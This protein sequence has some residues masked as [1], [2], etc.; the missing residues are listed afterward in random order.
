[1]PTTPSADARRVSRELQASPLRE[2]L[3]DLY[4]RAAARKIRDRDGR[5]WP[6]LTDYEAA[7]MLGVERTS[8]NAARNALVKDGL[9]REHRKR[10]CRH[11]PSRQQVWAWALASVASP[12]AQP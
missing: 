4:R 5:T 3:L 1:M 2:R 6:G 9:V 11:K 12:A 7:A 8:I 10:P